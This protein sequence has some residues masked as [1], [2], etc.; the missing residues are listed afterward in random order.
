MV[1]RLNGSQSGYVGLDAPANAGFNT[2]TLPDSG[3]T[4][5]QVLTTDGNGVL[6]W[7]TPVD[8]GLLRTEGT[9]VSITGASTYTLTGIDAAAVDVDLFWEDFYT[10]GGNGFHIR[11]GTEE[12]GGTI[13]VNG[14]VAHAHYSSSTTGGTYN[15]TIIDFPGTGSSSTNTYDGHMRITKRDGNVYF[16]EAFTSHKNAGYYW[17]TIGNWTASSP[18][19]RVQFIVSGGAQTIAGGTAKVNYVK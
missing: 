3:G 2:L 14:Y 7:Q 15:T 13:Y 9:S 12:N 10:S 5:G 6:D 17:Q 4:N 1:L 18:L 11:L 16:F 19:T 8:T